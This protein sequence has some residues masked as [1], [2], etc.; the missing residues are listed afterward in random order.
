MFEESMTSM[1][2]EAVK[3][4]VLDPRPFGLRGRCK[5]RHSVQCNSFGP[6]DKT[7]KVLLSGRLMAATLEAVMGYMGMANAISVGIMSIRMKLDEDVDLQTNYKINYILLTSCS[8]RS[9]P[10]I[11][12]R[13][14]ITPHV[15]R[16]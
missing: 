12:K 9:E 1:T 5:M 10:R 6:H 8:E 2:S 13:P 4:Y 11:L 3:V 16:A 14:K 15:Q 7:C